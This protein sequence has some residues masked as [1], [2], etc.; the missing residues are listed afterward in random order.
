MHTFEIIAM[1]LAL[2]LMFAAVGVKI[3]TAHL[4]GRMKA[5]IAQVTHLKQEAMGRLKMIQS[6]KAV[7]EQGKATL[8]AKKAK[9]AKKVSRIQQEIKEMEEAEQARLKRSE[10]RKVE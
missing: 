5:Q 9:L 7:A 8:I 1:I 10:L 4:L 3:M 2:G 6:Q